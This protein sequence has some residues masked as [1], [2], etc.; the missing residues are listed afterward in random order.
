MTRE[1]GGWQ[2]G[3]RGDDWEKGRTKMNVYLAQV[4]K[5]ASS[6]SNFEWEKMDSFSGQAKKNRMAF[7]EK[8]VELRFH[9]GVKSP[10]SSFLFKISIV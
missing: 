6:R 8:F 9:K 7:F 10:I 5:S 3:E 2:D 4:S 1:V